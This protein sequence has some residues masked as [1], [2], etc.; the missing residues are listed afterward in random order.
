MVCAYI[1][2]KRLPSTPLFT[3]LPRETVCKIARDTV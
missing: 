2:V 3:W 1:E